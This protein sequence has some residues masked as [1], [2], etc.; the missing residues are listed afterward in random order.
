MRVVYRGT[1][2]PGTQLVFIRGVGLRARQRAGVGNSGRDGAAATTARNRSTTRRSGRTRRRSSGTA[3]RRSCRRSRPADMQPD[4]RPPRARR[5][6]AADDG[7]GRQGRC[8]A[9]PADLGAGAG[10]GGA[11]RDAAAQCGGGGAAESGAAVRGAAGETPL[12]RPRLRLLP[13]APRVAA[14]DVKTR[15]RGCS[16][17][18]ER[19]ARAPSR[20]RPMSGCSGRRCSNCRRVRS[21]RWWWSRTRCR[22]PTR[23]RDRNPGHSL[24][25]RRSRGRWPR[26]VC[27]RHPRWRA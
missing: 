8:A 26:Q 2:T 20:L 25:R 22:F 14:A 4:A 7:G 24:R 1:T 6:G 27:R 23:G 5:E 15:G 3:C 18:P 13:D 10:S 19:A 11:Q 16:S 12:R 9:G 21:R 17:R